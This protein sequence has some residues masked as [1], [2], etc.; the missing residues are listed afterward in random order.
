MTTNRPPWFAHLVLLAVTALFGFPLLWMVLCSL[1]S[2]VD[3]M[4]A[5]FALLPTQWR[6]DNYVEALRTMVFIAVVTGDHTPVISGKF[7][8]GSATS[9]CWRNTC[10]IGSPATSALS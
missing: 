4:T 5:P 6:F 9:T 8:I 2:G 7:G 1:K 10:R 3:L